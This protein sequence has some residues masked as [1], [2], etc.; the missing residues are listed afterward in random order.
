MASNGQVM[1]PPRK[2]C[3]TGKQLIALYET[4]TLQQIADMFGVTLETVRTRLHEA[5]GKC[6]PN[7]SWLPKPN[8]REA[9]RARFWAKVSPEPNSGCWLWTGTL[10]GGYGRFGRGSRRDGSRNVDLAPRVSWEFTHGPI[11][12][13]LH[14][15]HKC[16]NKACVNPDH[17]YLGTHAQNMQDAYDRGQKKP[18]R[19]KAGVRA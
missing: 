19:G 15:L 2:P 14:A 16:D 12:G 4:H 3:A 17:L 11:H 13:G 8:A 1:A 5:G 6:R 10:S 9:E 7:G 18:Y